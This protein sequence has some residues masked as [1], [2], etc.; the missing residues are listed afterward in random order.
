LS[1]PPGNR[2]SITRYYEV[3]QQLSGLHNADGLSD[4][5]RKGAWAE[6]SA[7]NFAPSD[8][9]P[10]GTHYGPSFVATRTDGTPFY[11]PDIAEIDEDII[12]HWEQRSE[13]TQHPVL[14]ARYA[15]IVWDLKKR[16]INKP[17]N[18]QYA[19]RAIDA[20]LDGITAETKRA[21]G[22]RDRQS[23]IRAIVGALAAESSA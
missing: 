21:P 20:Y 15:D 7:F 23:A 22:E 16:A 6:A 13:A 4:A 18:I 11:A 2:S 9:S 10:W 1:R 12:S 5:E 8:E 19:Q 14:R 17:A 3:A